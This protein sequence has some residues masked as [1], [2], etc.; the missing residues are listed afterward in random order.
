MTGAV[1]RQRRRALGVTGVVVLV[2]AVLAAV[3]PVPYVLL[4]PGPVEN[5][6]GTHDGRPLI[7]IKGKRTYPASGALDLVTVYVS[8]GP[9]QRVSLLAAL[10]GWLDSSTAVVPQDEVYPPSSTQSEVERQNT[11]EMTSSQEAATVAALQHLGIP[12][13]GTVVVSE[14]VQGSPADGQLRPGD[15]IAEVDGTP[16][17]TPEDV[18]AAVRKHQPGERVS[19]TIRRKGSTQT[20]SLTTANQNGVAV[21]G[22]V[23]DAHYNFPFE[24][25]I[26]PGDIGGPSAGLMFTLGI[27]DLL[28]PGDLTGGRKIA[29]TGTIA[30]NGAVGP[31]G[32]I[33]QKMLGA[34]AAGA[35]WFLAP[36]G[37]CAAAVPAVPSGL[38]L[39][40]VTSLDSALAAVQTIRT[41]KGALPRCS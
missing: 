33:Q 7:A 36:A 41:G 12:F 29:G 22:F 31:I 9:G 17:K 35:K 40:K 38:T 30:P 11:Q 26:D 34:R 23:P 3:L 27:V 15:V 10:H 39:V 6:L 32:G 13:G 19:F 20:I 14:V 37:D 25:S 18:V 16:V 5:T 21:V 8:G 1:G 2:L 24:V 4:S 28:T